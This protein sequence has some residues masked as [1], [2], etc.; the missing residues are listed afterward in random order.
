MVI[1]CINVQKSYKEIKALNNLNLSIEKGEIYGL[2][3]P[4]GAGKSTLI[5]IFSSLLQHDSG[6]IKIQGA[7]IPYEFNKIKKHLGFIPQDL[8][9][10]EDLT[11]YENVAFFA[12]LYGLKGKIRKEKVLQALE[13]VG[14]ID[15]KN[16][17]AK[18]FSGG[19]K[20]RLNIACG[21]SHEPDI[22]FFDEPTVGIDPQSRN[23]ILNSIIKLKQKGNTIIYT[24]HY[25]EEA[26]SICDN[27]SIIDH[28]KIIAEGTIDQLINS[29]TEFELLYIE[30]RKES[31]T[32]INMDKLMEIRGVKSI[33][34]EE[35]GLSITYD[36]NDDILELLITKLKKMKVKV[37]K[38][39]SRRPNL[40]DVFLTL[41]GRNL[42]D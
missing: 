3:G 17:F 12:S 38:I 19:M 28:G 7:T 13:F 29:V 20:R 16:N 23:H 27:I 10:Y 22:I 33:K 42:R 2:L 1:E 21:I 18:T 41:T 26:Q 30:I 15:R 14:L 34:L 8:A 4:N 9:I 31:T 32:I 36:E 11:A 40:E 6:T 37:I 25:M 39:E 5:N 35:N 24:T